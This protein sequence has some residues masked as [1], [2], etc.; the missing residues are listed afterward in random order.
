[1][2]QNYCFYIYACSS[3]ADIK[4][5]AKAVEKFLIFSLQLHSNIVSLFKHFG[6][7]GF[8]KSLKQTAKTL[9]ATLDNDTH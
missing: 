7:Q 2:I 6:R 4:A 5:I 3:L 8:Q 9:A 1:V